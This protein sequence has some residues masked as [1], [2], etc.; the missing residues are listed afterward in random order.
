MIRAALN[1]ARNTG[2]VI[3]QPG[4]AQTEQVLK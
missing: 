2:I 1:D 4:I 3:C